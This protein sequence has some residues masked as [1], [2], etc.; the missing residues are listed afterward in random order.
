[1]VETVVQFGAG[2]I[3]R[4]F[5]GQLWTDAGFEVV[6]VDV[7]PPIID[8]LNR[9][10]AYPLRLV[11]PD[12][13][14]ARRI[15]PVRAVEGR[16]LDAVAAELA[17]CR[18]ACTAVGVAALPHLVPAL[19]RGIERRGEPLDVILCENQL[20]CSKLLR[21]LLRPRVAQERLERVGLVE[22]VVSRMVPPVPEAERAGAP[23]LAIAEDYELL[24]V[25]AAAFLGPRPAV[26]ALVPAEPFQAYVER[27]LFMH[28]MAHAAAAYLGYRRG[29]RQIH[30]AVADPAIREV[31]LGAL[32]ETALALR[33][34]WGLEAAEL[35]RHRD[36]L[37]RRFGNAALG[38]T[39]LRVGRDPVRKL[40]PEDRL[41]GAALTCLDWDVEPR[42]VA[43]ALAAALRFDHP[44]DPA[45]AP[46]RAVLKE[47][48]PGE[49]LHRFT[50]LHPDS[51]LGRRVLQA[52]EEA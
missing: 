36:D 3:G 48:G 8:A 49:A 42:C 6:F 20:H 17:R 41:V 37:L 4:G 47:D 22:S 32:D 2:N 40:R 29:F 30:E 26:P 23:L 27:K 33:R 7:S 43:R 51:E 25:D 5:V 13:F 10:R 31:V 34:K 38:D 45:A 1:M 14:E 19:A 11:G 15:A 52:F 28:N 12:R 46:L 50:G 35:A 24:P 44:E 18:F 39:V 16:D 9:E 21:E